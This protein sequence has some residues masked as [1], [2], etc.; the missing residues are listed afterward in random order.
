MIIKKSL[1]KTCFIL[2]TLGLSCSPSLAHFLSFDSAACVELQE[3]DQRR[4]SGGLE[5]Q[6]ENIAAVI[7]QDFD[8]ELERAM[9]VMRSRAITRSQ[10]L[11]RDGF[12]TAA[13][14][15]V[16]PQ[17]FIGD[18]GESYKPCQEEH[19]P[20]FAALIEF[21]TDGHP[22]ASD[23]EQKIQRKNHEIR[24]YMVAMMELFRLGVAI[25][26]AKELELKK[27][28]IEAQTQIIQKMPLLKMILASDSQLPQFLVERFSS[29]YNILPRYQN[30]T[31]F[32][33]IDKTHPQVNQILGFE[34]E[35]IPTGLSGRMPGPNFYHQVYEGLLNNSDVMQIDKWMSE[36]IEKKILEAT[37]TSLSTLGN[38]C[39]LSRC[40]LMD[41]AQTD[42]ASMLNQIIPYRRQ[43]LVRFVCEECRFGESPETYSGETRLIMGLAALGTGVGC[44]ISAPVCVPALLV[45]G[46]LTY[47]SFHHYK[48]EQKEL[49]RVTRYTQRE[50]LASDESR[51]FFNS[52]EEMENQESSARTAFYQMLLDGALLGGEGVAVVRGA[53]LATQKVLQSN[54]MQSPTSGLKLYTGRAL[55]DIPSDALE[56]F[57]KA[58]RDT[59]YVPSA[60]EI[61]VL[62]QRNL[63]ENFEQW[64]DANQAVQAVNTRLLTLYRSRIQ[65]GDEKFISRV[66]LT[67]GKT[68]FPAYKLLSRQPRS[69]AIA[70]KILKDPNYRLTRSERN[71]ISRKGL[72]QDLLRFRED[73]KIGLGE[74][75]ATVEK[76]KDAT[77]LGLWGVTASVVGMNVLTDEVL[78]LEESFDENNPD[79]M[80]RYDGKVEL[81]YTSPMPHVSIRIGGL[82]YNYGVMEVQR[83]NL[84]SYVQSVGFGASLSGNHIRIEL[85]LSDEEKRKLVD[86]LEKDV[87]KA[88]PLVM[89][90][91]DCISQTNKAIEHATGINVPV[92]MDRSQAMSIAYLNLL[93]ISGDERI[94]R[95]MM[96]TNDNPLIARAK[97]STVNVLDTVM[98]TRYAP[99]MIPTTPI[100]DQYRLT[101]DPETG[102]MR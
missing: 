4:S 75:F 49:E 43:Q 69:Q 14:L 50:A 45:G 34:S 51:P 77:H 42:L 81:I 84:D 32:N 33:D 6:I 28:L 56:I 11:L 95:V 46:G 35:T 100:L 74:G 5:E 38:I 52:F 31:Y 54:Y 55:R 58:S 22:L 2:I 24:R 88:Y 102:E 94:G 71:Y 76:I 44:L 25:E 30:V 18:I 1:H 16:V 68:L 83:Y 73:L 48:D 72:D 92:V 36:T 59:R 101:L 93:K 98:F 78:T 29:N 63:M 10:S 13:K 70:R 89:P 87:G 21:A 7:D 40:E 27:Q 19:T 41:L 96:A 23:E 20:E 86:Y 62:Q 8:Q 37:K 90:F 57:L 12:A 97:E 60:A 91:V 82:V 65:S 26:S 64:K 15:G 66:L 67:M 47:L 85:N 3:C 53:K 9:R 99:V 80:S 79:G 17:E 61:R 39:K